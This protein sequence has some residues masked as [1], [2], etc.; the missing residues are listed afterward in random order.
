[1]GTPDLTAAVQHIAGFTERWTARILPG[2][3]M[4]APARQFVFPQA[5][6]GEEDAL[7]RGALWLD[8]KPEGE[9]NFLAQCALGFAGSG[10]ATGVWATPRPQTLL[11]VAGGYGYLIDTTAPERTEFLEQRPVVA[12]H[13]APSANALVLVGFHTALVVTENDTWMSPR[14][15]WEGIAINGVEGHHVH[16]TGWHMP[17]DRELPF[18]LDLRER[19]ATGGGFIP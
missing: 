6:P 1:M 13:A 18:T 15:S 10:L 9:A 3:P 19:T 17:S 12:V 2:Q 7:A 5:V 11:A 14:L 8:I 4:I 16:G